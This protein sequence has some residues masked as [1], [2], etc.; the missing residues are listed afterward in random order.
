MVSVADMVVLGWRP[1]LDPLNLH[2][3]WWAFLVPLSFLISVTYRAVRMR[4]LTG[5]WRAV[6]VMTVQIILAMIG[7][8]VAAFIFVEYLIPWLAPMPS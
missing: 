7:L 6:G 2:S 1:F 5:Y 8:G 3:Q 4:D